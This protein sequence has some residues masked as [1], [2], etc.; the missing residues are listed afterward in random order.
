[1]KSNE[2]YMYIFG[3]FIFKFILLF[4]I[5]Q[6][7]K[8]LSCISDGYYKFN[9]IGIIITLKKGAQYDIKGNQIQFNIP[10][11]L[12]DH[13]VISGIVVSSCAT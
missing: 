9:I 1:M 6:Q 7:Q 2:Q 8:I 11:Q 13:G 5:L 3:K 10:F 4:V 12:S